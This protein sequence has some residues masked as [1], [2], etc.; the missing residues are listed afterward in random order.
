MQART[1]FKTA[2]NAKDKMLA[3][4]VDKAIKLR[5]ITV[6]QCT[7]KHALRRILFGWQY[8][9]PREVT[10]MPSIARCGRLDAGP[11]SVGGAALGGAIVSVFLLFAQ[12]AHADTTLTTTDLQ[13]NFT[14]SSSTFGLQVIDRTNSS[15]LLTQNS[16]SFN[17]L[18]VTGVNSTANNG[19][20]VTLGLKLSGGGTATA[21]YTAVNSDRV[22][23]GLTGP[24]AS[25]PTVTQSFVDQGDRY[26]GTWM[27]TY[28]NTTTS[29]PVSLNNRGISN[30]KYYGSDQTEGSTTTE[31]TRASYYFTN[32]NVGVYAETSAQGSY[33]FTTGASFTFDN[34]S[35]TYDI[36]RGGSPKGVLQAIRPIA[37]GAF[38]P[39]LWA[40]E[41]IWWRDDAHQL[42]GGAAN[43]Q[44]NVTQD[45]QKLQANH[46]VAGAIWLDR[47][48]G[49]GS[50]G[51]GGWG[52][53]D[54]DSS[55][56]N[57]TQMIQTLK[58][59]G[60]N[61][62][63]WIANRL[64]NNQLTE[65]QNSNGLYKYF[66]GST[67][68]PAADV[69]DP[70]TAAWFQN[71]LSTFV[72]L[73]VKGFKIDRG[74][75]GEM[76]NSVNN[77][78]TPLFAQLATQALS[79]VNGTDY[80]DFARNLNDQTR[81]YA[82]VWNGDTFASFAGLT[83][84][85]TNGIRAGLTEFP[86]FGSDTG[87]YKNGT[88]TEELFDRW[89][90]YSAYTPMMEILIGPSR[91]PWYD[92]SSQAVTIAAK[93]S[94]A[95]HDLIPYV[96]SELAVANSTGVPV[97][98]AMYLEFPNDPNPAVADM[99][100]QY[101]YGP[102]LLVAP[103]LQSGVTGRSV[104]LPA[105]TRWVN[106]NDKTTVYSGGQTIIA[107]APLDT[108]PVFAREGTIIPHGDIDKANQ[109]TANWSPSLTIDVFPSD[110]VSS[111][112]FD[113]YTDSGTTN[114]IVAA[115]IAQ[116]EFQTTFADLGVNGNL[117]LYL[118]RFSQFSG[119][120]SVQN[121]GITLS[122]G[123]GYTFNAAQNLLVIP[124]TGATNAI[125]AFVSGQGPTPT[126][127]GAGGNGNWSAAT[128]WSV[129][130][131]SGS[132]LVF[133]GT[134]QTA[135]TNDSLSDVGGITFN[136]TAGSF[137]LSGN[138]LLISGGITNYS[139]SPQ[140]ITLNLTLGASQQFNAATGNLAANG[141]IANA[142]YTLTVA[143]AAN[144][145]VTGAISGGGGLVKNDS[146]TLTLLGSNTYSGST[147]V[148]GGT[149][150]V[151]NVTALGSG[152][153]TIN[154]GATTRLQTGLSAPVQLPSLTIAGGSSPS[155]TLDMS[156]NN[157]V[158][159]NG[160]IATTLAQLKSGLN[161]SSALW[162]GAG[163]NS[164][165]AAVDA[166]AHS[167]TTL[168]AVGAILN[169]DKNGNAN[170]ST[171]PALP[172]PDTGVTGLTTTD[173][174]VKYTYFG[175][176]D[177][178]GVVDNTTDYDLWSN[179][180]TNPS[181]A[182][183]N[184]WLYGDFDFSGTVDNT[185]DYDLWSTGF[186]HQGGALAEPVAPGVPSTN[187]GQ[188]SPGSVTPA[189]DIQAVPEPSALALTAIAMIGIFGGR[190]SGSSKWLNI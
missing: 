1:A 142:G 28:T 16:L 51:L 39:P 168:F 19:T 78:E 75:E 121:N 106:F 72:N 187:S 146:G 52:N 93:Q 131:Q 54:F 3:R 49:T 161:S 164:S 107:S 156:N 154:A 79:A 176:A 138:G 12:S 21:I 91:T 172:S 119:I 35:L 125:V 50:T 67:S 124:Y 85:V 175:D 69:T 90:G 111:S 82:A 86:I 127:T 163:I 37:G 47:P 48:Y 38:I 32:K 83:T 173:V 113:Y 149:I 59:Y 167:N 27:N 57:P 13:L 126:W 166:A 60:I 116:N 15:L 135:T 40:M 130:P 99:S 112:S 66:N 80:Y 11:S 162:T 128:N 151:A 89:I 76:P 56:P 55:F 71:K 108:V 100:D 6:E 102:N 81:Q 145:T 98:R 136:N 104:Y 7:L 122:P 24:S 132:N 10:T 31:G 36:L 42:Q 139:A 170:Y 25:S 160:V 53:Y 183:T 114:T 150:V 182:A 185:T 186:A 148:S 64:S 43:A 4:G 134:T 120:A 63:L 105:G 144:T 165:T 70:T 152:R 26:Y 92:F 123:S 77:I 109:T 181:L 74:G 179:G 110:T 178:N 189:T 58:G 20:T 68:T 143:G 61:T 137:V 5:D 17:G 62:M 174:L 30:G 18:A 95:H 96:R 184:G 9:W 157:L 103:V 87:G 180:F 147:T 159:H 14:T 101:M 45:A 84:T 177:L 33:D 133:A 141:T 65:A 155:A 29:S 34:S 129:A 115:F 171:W 118:G 73:G 158:L 190:F 23:V 140:L 22:Q 44:A 169:I 94:Q 88:P 46:I 41:S 188:E 153:L 97:I 117:D 8:T 2:F